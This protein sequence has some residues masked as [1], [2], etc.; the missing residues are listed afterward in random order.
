M[1]CKANYKIVWNKEEFNNKYNYT[2][3]FNK[4]RCTKDMKYKENGG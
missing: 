1:D 4:R 2:L 3:H